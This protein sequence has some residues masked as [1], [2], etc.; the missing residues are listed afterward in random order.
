M[1]DVLTAEEESVLSMVREIVAEGRARGGVAEIG[2][3]KKT[4]ARAGATVAGETCESGTFILRGAR[5]TVRA[6][7]DPHGAIEL[8]FLGPEA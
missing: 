7:S 1:I 3:L 6:L 2:E 4:I 5:F 8:R